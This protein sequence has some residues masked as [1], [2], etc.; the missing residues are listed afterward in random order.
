MLS[1]HR[2]HKQHHTILQHHS[3]F[4]NTPN[5]YQKIINQIRHHDY[6]HKHIRQLDIK[7]DKL[8]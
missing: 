3:Q 5:T 6:F 8:A 2:E 1:Q 4:S 7:K